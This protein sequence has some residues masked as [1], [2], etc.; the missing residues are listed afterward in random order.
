MMG[1][2]I[3]DNILTRIVQW[4]SELVSY[5]QGQDAQLP[6]V[7][8]DLSTKYENTHH[9]LNCEGSLYVF[10]HCSP[11]LPCVFSSCPTT[12]QCLTLL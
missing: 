1:M 10:T 3:D 2:C 11:L 5:E 8:G 4:P 7:I 6:L 12:V 9:I